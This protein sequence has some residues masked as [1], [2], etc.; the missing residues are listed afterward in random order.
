MKLFLIFVFIII[1][2]SLLSVGG[3]VV[4]FGLEILP[5]FW[6]IQGLTEDL[7]ISVENFF[8]ECVCRFRTVYSV[9]FQVPVMFP[10][11]AIT[12]GIS[13]LTFQ[14]LDF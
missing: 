6:E 5:E 8:Q 3:M 9:T 12:P 11:A 13:V 1:E 4:N 2:S 10:S 7:G 14:S